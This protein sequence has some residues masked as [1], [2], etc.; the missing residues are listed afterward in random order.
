M[1]MD[2]GGT[3]RD[4]GPP[5][6]VDSGPITRD[7]GPSPGFDA[8]PPPPPPHD[9][10]PPPGPDAGP[11]SGTG[12]YLDRCTEGADCATG[13]CVLDVG[14]TSMCTITCTTHRDCAS[15]HV[16]L[17][18]LCVHDDTGT[19]CSTS[20]PETCTLGLCFGN[21]ATSAGQCTRQCD[22]AADCPAG[23][24]CANAS[25]VNVCVDIERPC[26]GPSDC[27]TGL[28]FP[29]QGC[30]AACR[31]A[32]DCPPRFGSLTAYTCEVVSGSST[33]VCA[34]PSDILGSDPVGAACR[35]DSSGNYLC[36]SRVCDTDAAAGPMC[37]QACTQEGGCGPGLGCFP[38]VQGS[39]IVLACS[40]GGSR[41]IG[42]S[43][44]RGSDCDSALCDATR[45]ICTRLCTDD[46][47]C[48]TG[49]TCDP[50]AGFSISICR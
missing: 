30:T 10:G 12:R 35:T 22:S 48:P 19:T 28:C 16:C 24:A 23:F 8:G 32:T 45:S 9:T 38:T 26:S 25:G 27:A 44:S 13:H 2:G 36:R 20:S 5:P 7:S 47:L 33:T 1:A 6:G 49:M 11:P 37:T 18:G 46:G 42:E 31:T 15:E 41:A 43:C 34:P 17:D 14:G 4:S 29:T 3:Q 50:V 39:D 21:A 40:R